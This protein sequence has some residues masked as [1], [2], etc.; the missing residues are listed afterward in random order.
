LLPENEHEQ[1]RHQKSFGN[2]SGKC[3]YAQISIEEKNGLVARG[4]FARL[5]KDS[6]SNVATDYTDYTD[7]KGIEKRIKKG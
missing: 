7:S 1:R 5:L 2:K 6:G 3:P 4:G